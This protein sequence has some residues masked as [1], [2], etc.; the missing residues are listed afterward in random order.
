MCDN[1]SFAR[2]Q[3]NFCKKKKKKMKIYFIFEQKERQFQKLFFENCC[4]RSD[5]ETY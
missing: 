2:V 5:F 1:V 4:F 3:G